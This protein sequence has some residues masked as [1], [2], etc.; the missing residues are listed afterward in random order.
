MK[1]SKL[2][3]HSYLTHTHYS[4]PYHQTDV[5]FYTVIDLSN[6]FFSVPINPDSQFWFVFSCKGKSYTYIY[7]PQGFAD[8]P[9]IFTQAIMNF[10][11]NFSPPGKSQIL[12]YED[13]TLLVSESKEACKADFL[14]L[15]K[16]LYKTGNKVNKQKLQWIRPQVDYLGQGCPNFL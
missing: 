11:A 8:R 1:L 14:A 2:E 3:L 13:D 15:L 16:H 6:A 4:I 5:K 7:L 10:L 9:T 12:V